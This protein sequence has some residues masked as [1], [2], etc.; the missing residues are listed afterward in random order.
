MK[1]QSL[2]FMLMSY[3]I[4]LLAGMSQFLIIVVLEKHLSLSLYSKYT[5]IFSF[6][7]IYQMVLDLGLQGEVIKRLQTG[8]NKSAELRRMVRLRLGTSIIAVAFALA[9]SFFAGLDTT[10]IV[11]V[12]VLSLCFIPFSFLMNLEI[13]GYSDRKWYLATSSRFGKLLGAI[14]FVI[15]FLTA[16]SKEAPATLI[17]GFSGMLF[18]Y[19][20][21][22]AVLYW[23][24]RVH[25]KAYWDRKL[26]IPALFTSSYGII[27]NFGFWWLFGSLFS[28]LNIRLFGADGLA[29]FNTAFV[30]MTPVSLGVQ[31]GLNF[32]LTI[33]DDL[34][35]KIPLLWGLSIIFTIFYGLILNIDSFFGIFFKNIDHTMVMHCL[36][37]LILAH[38]ILAISQRQAII[39]Q[40]A[41]Y[42]NPVA[43]APLVAVFTVGVAVIYSVIYTMPYYGMSYVFLI[44]SLSYF[45]FI[46]SKW[47]KYTRYL[48][49]PH[50]QD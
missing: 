21:L 41:S 23:V 9:H 17:Y 32:S 8:I 34:E 46:Y 22:A 36:W 44:A 26:G 15:V 10:L 4:L 14:V 39:L 42:K 1:F 16:K 2:K 31:L 28:V 11:G 13:V 30:L 43:F 24:G 47:L 5:L 3:C 50:I 45:I 12:L 19:S 20:V 18:T 37:P 6:F 48:P 27:V 35:K 25:F 49:L 7:P 40:S 33:K 29:V 38:P